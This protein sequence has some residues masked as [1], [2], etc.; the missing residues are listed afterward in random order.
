MAD[1][2]AVIVRFVQ[3]RNNFIHLHSNLLNKFKTSQSGAICIQIESNNRHQFCSCSPTP[4]NFNGE[5]SLNIDPSFAQTL[6]L[7]QS[8]AVIIS[9]AKSLQHLE[10]IYVTPLCLDDWNIMENS[11]ETIQS[12][13]LNQIRVVNLHQIFK[14]WISKSFTVEVHV[15]SLDSG[16]S[17]GILESN[18][19]VIVS[20][21][22]KICNECS[23][24]M[25]NSN[26]NTSL[27]VW[28]FFKD[29]FSF[30]VKNEEHIPTPQENEN[31]L[32]FTFNGIFRC[33]PYKASI[34]NFSSKFYNF[35]NN[36]FV[37]K[38]HLKNVKST[39]L[40]GSVLCRLTRIPY[41]SS[42]L[43]KDTKSEENNLFSGEPSQEIFAYLHLVDDNIVDK[44]TFDLLNSYPSIFISEA[45]QH[46]VNSK[47]NSK[48]KLDIITN[49]KLGN[50]VTEINYHVFNS[51]NSEDHEDISVEIKNELSSYA[52]LFGKLILNNNSVLTLFSHS[53]V[54]YISFNPANQ[55]FVEMDLE[56]INICDFRHL[57]REI[58][59]KCSNTVQKNVDFEVVSLSFF[60][61]IV[62]EL[63]N[64]FLLKL[65]ITRPKVLSDAA[66]NLTLLEGDSGT[67]KT[68]LINLFCENLSSSEYGIFTK[69]ISCKTLKGKMIPKLK[70]VLTNALLE[71]VHFQPAVLCLDDLD[72]LFFVSKEN[73]Q[74][75]SEN[76]V[77]YSLRLSSMIS[78]LIR[79]FSKHYVA[80]LATVKDVSCLESCV[81][82]SR[83]AS[84]FSTSLRIPTLNQFMRQESFVQLLS[85]RSNVL[86]PE[87]IMEKDNLNSI[88]ERM[89]GYCIQDMFDLVDRVCFESVKRQ[90]S[91]EN[92]T[93]ISQI[94]E[95][96]IDNAIAAIVPL[97]LKGIDFY[98]NSSVTWKDVGG[99]EAAKQHLM[100]VLIWPARYPKIFE[101]CPLKMQSGVL[102]FGVPGCGKTLLAS[103]I[104]GESGLNFISIKGPELLSKF[105]GASE[106]GIRNTFRKAQNARPC[107]L[108]FDE[109]DSLAPRRGN[110]IT[111]A[112]DRVV[113]QLLT[114]LDGVEAVSGVWTLA[115]TSRPDLID[116]ALLRP[117]RLGTLVHCPLPNKD[118]RRSILEVMSTSMDLAE[119]VDLNVI[120]KLT[121]GYTGADLRAILYSAF[122]QADKLNQLQI[123]SNLLRQKPEDTCTKFKADKINMQCLIEA[124]QGMKPSLKVEER[125]QYEK[126]YKRFLRTEESFDI[127]L[128][129]QRLTYA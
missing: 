49:R 126:T 106:E 40:E 56:D 75:R 127:K 57:F 62:R 34:F 123:K 65:K 24:D 90:V 20:P 19:R 27:N 38:A 70:K 31:S 117:G 85:G 47:M 14:I 10:M 91:V 2:I 81:F 37:S 73:R 72:V 104:A 125:L 68:T 76:G 32:K 79:S 33:V 103:A 58:D 107:I 120:A 118:E 122:I 119:D 88:V 110:D 67:G 111:G 12:T 115:A 121:D 50:K 9:P 30:A 29:V 129:E 82:S 26:G 3:V 16:V 63:K 18:T 51:D 108:F 113:N 124:V 60:E 71:C 116:P 94:C 44:V 42:K 112:T 59:N 25:F 100:E 92:T 114:A 6:G 55:S 96:D 102:L 46:S 83:G 15:D 17:C 61:D 41:V 48:V 109:F 4:L 93:Q 8:D 80:V 39:K 77:T 1:I 5:N 23:A 52:K 28:D 84:L 98:K 105:V 36:I 95:F 64:R 21:T 7:K 128:N 53:Y 87:F 43:S 69:K 54:L 35:P 74:E 13:L 101:Q 11:A 45:V 22:P 78:D 99:L 97:S 86:V 89:N 66:D